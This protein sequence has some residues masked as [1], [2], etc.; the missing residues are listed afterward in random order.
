MRT[1][2]EKLPVNESRQQLLPRGHRHS[3]VDVEGNTDLRMFQLDALGMN[4]VTPEQYPLAFRAERIC[5]LCC[6]RLRPGCGR[7]H[8][9]EVAACSLGL[10][11]SH[12]ASTSGTDG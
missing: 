2:N 5:G 1:R 6:R 4:G 7:G 10:A 11:A 9:H 12:R 8:T 3:R